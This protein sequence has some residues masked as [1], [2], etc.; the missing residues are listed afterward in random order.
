MELRL[1]SH[2]PSLTQKAL[3]SFGL[4]SVLAARGRVP[5]SPIDPRH[6]SLRYARPQRSVIIFGRFV[7]REQLMRDEVI[8]QRLGVD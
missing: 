7:R 6:P 3:A 1:A 2:Q 5:P 8:E 4:A